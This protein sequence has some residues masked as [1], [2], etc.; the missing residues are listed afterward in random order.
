MSNKTNLFQ[1]CF[2]RDSFI[3]ARLTC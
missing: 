3:S 2:R 1:V